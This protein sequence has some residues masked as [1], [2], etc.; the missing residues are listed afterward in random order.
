MSAKLRVLLTRR[1][2]PEDLEYIRARVDENVE[3][4]SP[5][6]FDAEALGEAVERGADA[7]LGEPPGKA[8]LDKAVGL[9]LIQVPWAG[10]ERLD[11][12][13]L[14]QYPFIVCNSH[15]NARV[16]AEYACSLLLSAAKWIPYH[17]RHLRGGR[18]CR[19]NVGDA[20]LFRPPESL[21]HKTLGIVGYGAVGRA[22]AGLAAGFD[23]DIQAVAARASGETPPPL[24]RLVAPARLIDVAADADFL[25]LTVP[26]T[27]KTRG[28][29]DR[30]IFDHMKQTA[31]LINIS[32]GEVVVE[33]DFY[34]VLS[35]HRIAG[36][37]IDTW[38]QYPSADRPEVLPSARFPFHEL[39]NLVL[40][41][42]RAGFARGELPHLDDAIENLNRL[43][44]GRELLNVVD[45]TAG[46]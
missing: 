43:A 41:P 31:Y 35:D 21:Q 5:R 38:Y 37:A 23:M 10:L 14:R 28:M 2:M 27:D 34:R 15:G 17:D 45:L 9:R 8:V 36:A 42:H 7:L 29:I 30:R 1:F 3:L 26:L 39:D 13:L 20:A 4:T 33:E 24:S 32:R 19:P 25:A 11:F 6:A 16:V 18:W 22:L 12:A 46:Y 40:S 44:S